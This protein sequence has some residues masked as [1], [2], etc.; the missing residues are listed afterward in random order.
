MTNKQAIDFILRGQKILRIQDWDIEF[1]PVNAG[2]LNDN[3]D[4]AIVRHRP[5]RMDAQITVAMAED[6]ANIK[7]S[8]WHE[9]IHLLLEGLRDIANDMAEQLGPGGKQLAKDRLN[10]AEERIA[11]RLAKALVELDG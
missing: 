8:I 7:D 5:Y 11:V 2:V 3:N 4:T 1:I 6:E 9:L 10:I